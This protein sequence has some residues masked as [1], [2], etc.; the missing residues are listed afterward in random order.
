MLFETFS[1]NNSLMPSVPIFPSD[2]DICLNNYKPSFSSSNIFSIYSSKDEENYQ[3]SP[4]RSKAEK[5]IL[6]GSTKFLDIKKDL[7]KQKKEKKIKNQKDENLKKLNK[8]L[9][10]KSTDFNNGRWTQEEH[11]KFIESIIKFGNEWRKVEKHIGTRSSTQARSHAQKFFEKMKLANL[12]DENLDLN[13]KT[14]IKSLQEVL[15][16]MEKEK[17]LYTVESLRDFPCERKK[18]SSKTLTK[19]SSNTTLEELPD[20]FGDLESNYTIRTMASNIFHQERVSDKINYSNSKC[21]QITNDSNQQLTNTV[22]E[23]KFS[24]G[25]NR[26]NQ[27]ESTRF[28]KKKRNR[29]MSQN[30]VDLNQIIGII[31]F[32][33]PEVNDSDIQDTIIGMFE[34]FKAAKNKDF[35]INDEIKEICYYNQIPNEFNLNYIVTHETKNCEELINEFLA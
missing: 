16:H 18:S 30:S 25:A 22:K 1:S 12:V 10:L 7:T 20:N 23:K 34:P 9:K 35:E 19:A 31:E 21:F 3:H 28:V 15:K 17:Y 5:N 32:D 24:D 11:K 27:L 6:N 2:D 29:N 8:K 4:S 33:D 14:S 13:N 26:I